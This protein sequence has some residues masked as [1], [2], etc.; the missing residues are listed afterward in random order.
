MSPLTDPIREETARDGPSIVSRDDGRRLAYAEYG[1]PT[2]DPVVFFHGTPGSRLLAGLF[3]DPAR[4]HGIRLLSPDRPGY[5]RS[6]PR[7]G[8]TVTDAADSTA[9]VLDDA[10]VERADLVAFSGGAPY[11]LACAEAIDRVRSVDVVAGATPPGVGP[12]PP[13]ARLLAGLATATPRLLGG[14]FRGQAWL[15]ARLDPSVVV[16]QYTSGDGSGAVPDATAALVRRD[17]LEAVARSRR[18]AV[19]EF[20]LNAA[21]WGIAFGSLDVPVRLWHGTADGNVPVAGARAFADRL[22]DADLTELAG[23]DHLHA[24][25]AAVPA[26]LERRPPRLA[27][28]DARP[29]LWPV[30]TTGRA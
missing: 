27:G 14:L 20:R 15:A 21:D 26:A 11:A 29:G 18:G 12:D 8:R 2:G 6:A 30:R 13:V 28:R 16:A 24:L 22:P 3:D 5:G 25:L 1:D 17:F 23:A 4:E 7:P 19:T 9:A 10:G